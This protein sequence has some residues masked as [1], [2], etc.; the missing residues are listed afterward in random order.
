MVVYD[1]LQFVLFRFL[2][3]L[4]LYSYNYR[5]EGLIPK[6]NQI[7]LFCEEMNNFMASMRDVLDMPSSG[8]GSGTGSGSGKGKETRGVSDVALMAEIQRI[9]IASTSEE[10]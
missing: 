1:S 6:M 5:L 8:S 2:I 3:C 9:V 7:Y 4:M 10:H